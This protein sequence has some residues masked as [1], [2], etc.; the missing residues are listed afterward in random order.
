VPATIRRLR[1]L[2]IVVA[3]SIPLFLVALIVVL[4]R[5]AS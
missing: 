4:W 3:V 2:L 5:L 1:M